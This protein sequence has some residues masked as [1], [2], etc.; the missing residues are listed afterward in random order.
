MLVLR[1]KVPV[2]FLSEG[3]RKAGVHGMSQD[4]FGVCRLR[5]EMEMGKGV[6][7]QTIQIGTELLQLAVP[8]SSATCID[9]YVKKPYG[10]IYFHMN[11]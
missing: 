4:F 2:V 5:L 9:N 11:R 7:E 1:G 6:P 3:E 10:K 8:L